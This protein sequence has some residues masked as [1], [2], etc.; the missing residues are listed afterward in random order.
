MDT[1]TRNDP[2]RDQIEMGKIFAEMMNLIE[3]T[4]KKQAETQ[5]LSAETKWYLVRYLGGVFIAAVIFLGAVIAAVKA[6]LP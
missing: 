5:K 1:S 2:N 6:F 4:R 3:D